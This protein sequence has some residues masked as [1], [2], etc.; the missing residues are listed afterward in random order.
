MRRESS[1]ERGKGVRTR[2]WE[3]LAESR[4]EGGNWSERGNW[5]GNGNDGEKESVGVESEVE[6]V[7][8][9]NVGKERV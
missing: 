6:R 7:E 8:S 5:L 3:D 4:E 9:L 1:V 2:N